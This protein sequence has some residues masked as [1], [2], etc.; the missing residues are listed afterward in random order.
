MKELYCVLK[1]S[2]V[3]DEFPRWESLG[4]FGSYEEATSSLPGI[5]HGFRYM[6][7]VAIVSA[8][9]VIDVENYAVWFGV[10]A[11]DGRLLTA[12]RV[13]ANSSLDVKSNE[14]LKVYESIDADGMF[15]TDM[16]ETMLD[17]KMILDCLV[18]CLRYSYRKYKI[19]NDNIMDGIISQMRI[20][21]EG[22]NVDIDSC[23]YTIDSNEGA[24]ALG[25]LFEY[26]HYRSNKRHGSF[27]PSRHSL[28]EFFNACSGAIRTSFDETVQHEL[29]MAE[30]IRSIAPVSLVI[31][32]RLGEYH[33]LK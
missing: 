9:Y 27:S 16:I 31:L 33:E 2:H 21:S 23:Y 11:V 24:Y 32:S 18:T 14:W 5:S 1:R 29:E 10:V 28:T 6:D 7:I 30:I 4:Y 15:L 3:V 19:N 17:V 22:G 26:I 20:L 8:E 25:E 12:P 13:V